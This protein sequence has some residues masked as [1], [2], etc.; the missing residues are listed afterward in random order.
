MP[1]HLRTLVVILLLASAI[2]AA[3]RPLACAAAMKDEDFARRRNAWF[4]LTLA[5]FLAHNFWIFMIFASALL[6]WAVLAESNKL[7]LYFFLLFAVPAMDAEIPGFGVV[8]HFF[9]IDYLRLLSL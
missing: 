5:A 3:A 2:F 1:E 9:A 8:E 7:A 4:A 6:L